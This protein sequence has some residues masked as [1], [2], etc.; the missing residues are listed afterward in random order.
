MMGSGKTTN[1]GKWARKA[2]L[3]AYDLDAMIE[4]KQGMPIGDIFAL[5]GESFFRETERNLLHTFG[6]KDNFILA[7]GGGVPCFFDNMKWMN[8]QGITIWLNEDVNIL[9]GR[10]KRAKAHR[11]L[12]KNLNDKDLKEYLDNKMTEREPY[13][14][15]AKYIFTSKEI[16]IKNFEKVINKNYGK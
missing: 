3:Q 12:L 4:E 15:K 7:T 2:G 6:K 10:L 8:N 1:S 16:S 9:Y 14:S 11:P 5:K 13:Y